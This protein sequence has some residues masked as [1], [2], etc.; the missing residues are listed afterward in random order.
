MIDDQP[1]SVWEVLKHTD[2][3]LRRKCQPVME[4]EGLDELV[5]EMIR[6]MRYPSGIGLAAPQIGKLLRV[7]VVCIP[8]GHDTLHYEVANPEI[9]WKSKQIRQ[10][11]EG[12]LSFPDGFRALVPRHQHIKVRGFN[13]FGD[14]IQFGAKDLMA[15]VLQHEIEHLDGILITDN[16]TRVDQR[17]PKTEDAEITIG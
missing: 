11:W 17:K 1:E 4:C 6:A 5:G 2:P 9:Y 10:E 16:A 7:V 3:M 12:C 14:N 15:R 13:R 8:H